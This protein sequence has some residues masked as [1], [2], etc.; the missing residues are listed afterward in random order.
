MNI[1]LPFYM[2]SF[3][4]YACLR[5]AFSLSIFYE[6]IEFYCIFEINLIY[7][8]LYNYINSDDNLNYSLKLATLNFESLFNSKIISNLKK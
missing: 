3:S 5:L 8:N 4:L 1:Y 7:F 2:L 6:K